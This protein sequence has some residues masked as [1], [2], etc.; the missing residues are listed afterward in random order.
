MACGAKG[1]LL[2][3]TPSVELAQAIRA[4]NKGYTQM[5][6]NTVRLVSQ[7]ILSVP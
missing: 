7:V 2:K 4:V 5:G 1:Y 3:D 6:P